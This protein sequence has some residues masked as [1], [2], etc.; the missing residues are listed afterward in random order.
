MTVLYI[1]DYGTVGGAT[2]SFVEMVTQLKKLGVRP[3]VVTSKR[4]ELNIQLENLGIKTV[5]AGHYTILEPLLKNKM[6]WPLVLLR[7]I[8]RYHLREYR[9]LAKLNIEID[10]TKIDLIHTNSARNS[11]GCRLNKKYHIPH[12]MHI[13]EFADADFNC[14]PLSPY[15]KLYNKY[16]TEFIS[17]SEN[18]RQHW[19]KKGIR[20][21]KIKTIY[22]GICNEDI[23]ISCNEDKFNDV[24]RIVIV[25]G[26]CEAKG[27]HLA[28]EAIGKVPLEIQKHISLD[29]IGW[30]DA[31]YIK[32]INILSEKYKIKDKINILGSR[33]DVHE[34]LN[35]YQIGLM[36]SRAEGFGRTTAEYMHARLGVIASNTGANPELIQNGITGLLY[37]SGDSSKLA[38]CI[39]FFYYNRN[40]LVKMSINAQ[41]KALANFTDKLNANKIFNLYNSIQ[42]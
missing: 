23:L 6:K 1:L 2:R 7:N 20:G 32:K 5:A 19:I 24:I 4:N 38:E 42:K 33:N 40:E 25:G 34:I 31:E 18:V 3:I 15:I 9:A 37:D 14:V 28:V 11:L 22:N 30:T 36:C 26:V 12:I 17:I 35:N 16:T 39:A 21:E 41:K 8:L 29:I 13:R 27:Q 10:F